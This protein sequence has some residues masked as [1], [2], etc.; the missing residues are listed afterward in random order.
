MNYGGWGGGRE[1]RTWSWDAAKDW[2]AVP[3]ALGMFCILELNII[4]TICSLC[5]SESD[6]GKDETLEDRYVRQ[7]SGARLSALHT[8]GTQHC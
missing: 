8:G 6:Q 3:E 7:T 2:L 5:V 1:A 4:I